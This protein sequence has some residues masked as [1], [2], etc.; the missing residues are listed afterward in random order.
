[1]APRHPLR[2][3]PATKA[4]QQALDNLPNFGPNGN[5]TGMRLH[6]GWEDAM[7]VKC[8]AYVYDCT[9]RP[10]IYNRAR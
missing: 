5:L 7:P 2:R 10:E 8:G 4:N 9:S 6:F 3:L 1:M